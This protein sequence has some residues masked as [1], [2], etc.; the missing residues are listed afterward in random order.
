MLYEYSAQVE[1]VIDADTCIVSLDLGFN[2][3]F[4]HLRIRLAHIDSPELRTPEGQVARTVLL[5]LLGPLPAQVTMQTLKDRTDDYGRY[6]AEILTAEG[7]NVNQT[8]LDQGYAKPW[9]AP[10]GSTP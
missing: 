6:L 3:W 4:N 1:R 5:N 9:P 8:L 7:V 2:I 10:K